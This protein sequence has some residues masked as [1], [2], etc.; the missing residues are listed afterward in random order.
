MYKV[1]DDVHLNLVQISNFYNLNVCYL[2]LF[3][4]FF[5]VRFFEEIDVRTMYLKK[6][7]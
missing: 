5:Y 4:S 2:L 1:C 6:K 3:D 7:I